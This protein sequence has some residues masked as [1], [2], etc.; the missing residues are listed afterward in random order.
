TPWS[1]HEMR[2]LRRRWRRP[3]QEESP[4]H[5]SASGGRCEDSRADDWYGKR[6]RRWYSSSSC[7]CSSCCRRLR[8]PARQLQ[9]LG[10][11][12]ASNA[13]QI[14]SC[15]DE[16]PFVPAAGLAPVTRWLGSG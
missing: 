3:D 6:P 11:P 2:S 5:R 16:Q 15:R 10:L 12:V 9:S 7:C 13:S 14:S 4:L 1:H 8:E